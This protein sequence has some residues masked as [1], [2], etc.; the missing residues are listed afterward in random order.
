MLGSIIMLMIIIAGVSVMVALTV[1]NYRKIQKLEDRNGGDDTSTDSRLSNM[2]NGINYNDDKL[3]MAT[4]V[5]SSNVNLLSS[6]V[7]A[8]EAQQT[9][10]TQDIT[11]L[12]SQYS[13]V[14]KPV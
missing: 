4:R 5:V 2:V 3:S 14:Y 12:K 13:S 11:Y 10:N 6:R 9:K 7:D 8:L 1:V